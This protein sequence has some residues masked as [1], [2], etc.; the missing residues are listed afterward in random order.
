VPTGIVV[1]DAGY[2]ER[3]LPVVRERLLLAG[4]RLAALLNATLGPASAGGRPR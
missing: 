1:L 2:Q 4:A 3:A